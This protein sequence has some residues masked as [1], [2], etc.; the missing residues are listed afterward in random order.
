MKF[1]AK[2]ITAYALPTVIKH[3]K[4]LYEQGAVKRV[5]CYGDTVVA[6]VV[7]QKT[8]K[9]VL[10][11]TGG[12]EQYHFSC[13]CNFI[14]GG[15]CAHAVAAMHAVNAR[16]VLQTLLFTDTDG[17]T[18]GR[19]TGAA[20]D[21]EAVRTI[22]D[23]ESSTG[24][25]TI[26]YY[27]EVPE[28]FP[29]RTLSPKPVGRIYVSERGRDLLVELRCAYHTGITDREWVE[30]RRSDTVSCRYVPDTNDTVV[31][32][33]RSKAR[34]NVLYKE[35]FDYNLTQYHRGTFIPTIDQRRWIADTL[36]LLDEKGFEI[37]GHKKLISSTTRY[38][39]PKLEIAVQHRGDSFLCSMKADFGGI[40]ASL[41]ALIQA[42]QTDSQYI[43]LNDGSSGIM[44]AVWMRVLKKVFTVIKAPVREEQ[45]TIA[46]HHLPVLDVLYEIA[47]T[48][49]ADAVYRQKIDQFRDFTGIEAQSLPGDFNGTLRPYQK[50]GYDWIY[51]L[52]KFHFGGC[53]ADDMGLGKTVQTLALLQNE[54]KAHRSVKASIVVVPTSVLFNWQHEARVFTPKLLVAVYYGPARKRMRRALAMADMVLTTYGT[55]LRDA[56]FLDTLAFNYIILD[57]AQNIKNPASQIVKAVQ[58]LNGQ[59]KLALTGTPIENSLSEL[60]SLFSFLN[61]GMLGPLSSFRRNIVKPVEVENDRE[62]L[63]IVRKMI[64]PFILRRTK[65]QVAK[66][67]PP[68]TTSI[69]Y[70]EMLPKQCKLYDITREA[71]LGAIIDSINTRGIE[72]SG[73]KII[74]GMLRLRQVCCHPK[75]IQPDFTGGSGKFAL[76]DE[77]LETILAESHRVL[78]F[79][80]FEAVLTL[81]SDSFKQKYIPHEMLT[82]K[83]RNREEAVMNFKNNDIPVFLISLKAGGVGLNL[84]EADY[85]IHMD[86]WW[87]PAAENQATDRAFRIG[88]T[89]EVF[90]YKFITVN[91]I[92]ERVLRMQEMKSRL[93]DSIIQSEKSFFK[94][95][96]KD[97]II[98][99]FS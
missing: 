64:F 5:Q 7:D 79:S 46:Q 30:F 81:I 65:Q 68:K 23:D 27:E 88:Q 42:A 83:T 20:I 89:K 22:P 24:E 25:T 90:V 62:S 66:E 72:R 43:R 38:G 41:A 16:E 71:Y 33:E 58:K 91:T 28:G 74:E 8:Y 49:S 47:D 87:N 11:K 48:K 29:V 86:P 82:G 37:Y 32:I 55:L 34:E 75:L 19:D 56:T 96:T 36:P 78:V 95:L 21:E 92:E 93:S 98:G 52:Q 10:S 45:F 70:T 31:C 18:T 50:A 51:F 53:L 2:Q 12:S 60:W 57:E 17:D 1:S 59:Y 15:A 40:P 44:P 14:H 54:K 84:T 67:L 26:A 94:H 4:E 61:P 99:L 9:A 39:K 3:G 77:Y 69:V 97:E 13:T 80:Q 63:E 73:M 85:V 76:F 6:E 35:L